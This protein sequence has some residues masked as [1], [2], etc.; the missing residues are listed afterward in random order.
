[1]RELSWPKCVGMLGLFKWVGVLGW[2]GLACPTACTCLLKV[3]PGVLSKTLSHI[4]GKLN[5]P[6]F[7]FNEGLFTLMNMDS[8]IF[9]AK[10]CPSLSPYYLEV[11]LGGGMTCVAAMM[12]YRGGFLQVLFEPFSKGPCGLPYVFIITGKVTTLEPVY[13]PTFFGHGVFVLG[14]DQ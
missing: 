13:D 2:L 7:L 10:P 1:M 6:I 4:W 9:L 5:L 11:M 8:L 12:M 3:R 14:V